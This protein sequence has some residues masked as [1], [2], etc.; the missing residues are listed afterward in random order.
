VKKL[1]PIFFTAAENGYAIKKATAQTNFCKFYMQ[2]SL[3]K[4]NHTSFR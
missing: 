1:D 4:N 2:Q 3:A